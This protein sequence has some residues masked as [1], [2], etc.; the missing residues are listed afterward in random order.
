MNKDIVIAL[1]IFI[2]VSALI[3]LVLSLKIKKEDGKT[4][5]A[6]VWKIYGCI[7]FFWLILFFTFVITFISAAN[8]KNKK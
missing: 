5:W 6:K 4:D 1:I 2:G 8:S 7:V 3:L